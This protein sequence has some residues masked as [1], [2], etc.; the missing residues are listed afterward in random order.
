MKNYYIVF[1][2]TNN[3]NNLT[4][5]E[6]K[7]I[8]HINY[9]N[10]NGLNFELLLLINKVNFYNKFAKKFFFN[11]YINQLP[12][13]LLNCDFIYVRKIWMTFSFLGLLKYI[14]KNS[15]A[16]IIMEIPTYPYDGELSK[17]LSNFFN[18]YLDKII[19]CK[20]K[21]YLDL[22]ITF[23]TNE[24]IFK[25]NT[26]KI[27]NGINCSM[28][29][30]R[31]ISLK[32]NSFHMLAV[33]QFSYWH[34]YDRLIKGLYY[35]YK[36]KFPKEV[37]IH[38]A[39]SGDSLDLYKKLVSDYKLNQYVLFEGFLSD[40]ELDNVFNIS[41][42]AVCSLGCHRKNLFLSSELKCFEYLARGIPMISSTKIDVIP[43]NYPYCLYVPE[44]ESPID[45]Q[46]IIDYY[47]KLILNKNI[48]EITNEIRQ[49]AEAHCDISKTMAPVISYLKSSV[50]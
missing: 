26:I 22:I 40:S 28:I 4:G 17:N 29:P 23:N 2:S 31:S 19:R 21:K 20:L 16:K 24:N 30:V 11:Y 37:F 7:I 27:S 33:A 14:H 6:K 34:G 47:D 18:F 15:K 8:S 48:T 36:N 25:I 43:E 1:S 5:V 46:Y 12:I 13:E 35:Y 38:F 49:F 42:L 44:D 10:N 32:N 45:I 39:G 9:F 50:S 41:D 3:F